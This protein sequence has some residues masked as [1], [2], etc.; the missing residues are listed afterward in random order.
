LEWQVA[1]V[2]RATCFNQRGTHSFADVHVVI[3]R[4]A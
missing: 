3:L 2:W 4:G 1:V